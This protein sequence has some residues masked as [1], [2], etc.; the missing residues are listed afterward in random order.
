MKRPIIAIPIII[1][2]I[3]LIYL[4]LSFNA[5]YY[6]IGHSNISLL[7]VESMYNFNEQLENGPIKISTLGDS[8]T[9]GQ[10]ADNFSEAYPYL[11]AK[12]IAGEKQT[13]TLAPFAFP[14]AMTSDL[15][16]NY[17]DQVV[18]FQPDI[19][20]VLIGVNDLHNRVSLLEFKENYQKIITALKTNP[21]SKIYLISLPFIGDNVLMLPPYQKYFFEE[22]KKYNEVVK[23][24]AKENQ[25]EYIDITTETAELFKKSG[26][27]YSA[28]HFHP[29]AL[30]YK[31]FEQ[32]I[33]AGINQ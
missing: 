12:K 31:I 32:L 28:D 16:N 10:G 26:N 18:A 8:L 17:L 33:Y 9:Y 22:T 7:K 15:I 29:S 13:V 5:I 21:Q 2:G 6:R 3:L 1:F 23:A 20:T 14:G 27:H 24:L 30:G 4:L 25:V 11:L 19:A